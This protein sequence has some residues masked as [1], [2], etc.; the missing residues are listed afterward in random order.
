MAEASRHDAWQAGDRY[1]AYMG[2]W[3]RLVAPQYL[4]WLGA[5]HGMDWLD[6]GCGTGALSATILARSNPKSLIAIDPSDGFIATAKAAADDPRA[7][8]KVGDAQA[9]PLETAGRDVAV[10]GLVLNFVPDRLKALEEM[11]RVVR[12]GGTVGFYVWDYPGG[13]LEFVRAFWTAATALDQPAAD[14]TEDRRF[15]FCTLDALAGL[16]RSAGPHASRPRPSRW[17]RCSATSRTTGSRSPWARDRRP[18]IAQASTRR[19]SS[20]SRRGCATAFPAPGMGPFPSRRGR[21][22]SRPWRDI[23]RGVRIAAGD[24]PQGLEDGK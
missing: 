3:S 23:P 9:L 13:G 12:S 19:R 21:S 8:F 11:K 5:P 6:V 15:P 14:L 22:Q 7:Q 16:A 2:R 4:D 20:A 18:A 10:S 1:D 24:R 17:R